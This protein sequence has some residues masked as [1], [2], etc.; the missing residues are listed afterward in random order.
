MA[1]AN[2]L[3]YRTFSLLRF[4]FPI[5]LNGF[6]PPSLRHFPTGAAGLHSDVI[7]ASSNGCPSDAVLESVSPF[8]SSFFPTTGSSSPTET[9]SPFFFPNLRH[10]KYFAL[11]QVLITPHFFVP[12]LFSP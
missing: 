12:L 3:C 7:D 8:P 10:K 11:L 1:D 2:F 6:F 9:F 5:L 4:F